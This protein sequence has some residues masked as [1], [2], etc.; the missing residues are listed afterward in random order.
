MKKNVRNVCAIGACPQ[1]HEAGNK[2]ILVGKKVSNLPE[3][4]GRI[5]KD[6]I[7]LEVPR[8]IINDYIKSKRRKKWDLEH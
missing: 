6:E 2:L 4:K 1:I 3:L 8:K 5:G 7:A